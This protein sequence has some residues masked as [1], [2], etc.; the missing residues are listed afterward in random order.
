MSFFK[1]MWTYVKELQ[2]VITNMAKKNLFYLDTF[3]AKYMK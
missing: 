2:I 3:M 1:T